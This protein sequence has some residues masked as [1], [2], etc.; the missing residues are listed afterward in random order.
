MSTTKYYSTPDF[1]WYDY[2]LTPTGAMFTIYRKPTDTDKDV[3]KAKKWLKNT[4]DVVG[5]IV[6]IKVDAKGKIL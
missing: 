2:A 6:T 3:E 4:R 1:I 5:S